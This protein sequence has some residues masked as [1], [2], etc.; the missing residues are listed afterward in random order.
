M[1]QIN[2]YYV[3]DIGSGL[4]VG[5]KLKKG[6]NLQVDCGSLKNERLA[7]EKGLLKIDPEYFIISH[8][9]LDHYNGLIYYY[10]NKNKINYEST[11]IK[12]V[13]FP[14]IPKTKSTTRLFNIYK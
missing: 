4:V 1:K 2:K 8:F 12:E 9:H 11:N 10:K 3:P 6:K 7:F 14:K 5:V 13:Y